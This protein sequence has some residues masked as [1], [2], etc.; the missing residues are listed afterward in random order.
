MSISDKIGRR[1]RKI[2]KV[3]KLSRKNDNSDK[4]KLFVRVKEVLFCV[5]WVA[6]LVTFTL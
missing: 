1:K 2:L 4:R 5:F 6:L 3:F